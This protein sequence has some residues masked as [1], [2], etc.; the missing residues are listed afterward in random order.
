MATTTDDICDLIRS[1]E[2]KMQYKP[3]RTKDGGSSVKNYV[4]TAGSFNERIDITFNT[5]FV[6]IFAF[7]NRN[8]KYY[9]R[10]SLDVFAEQF[11]AEKI[12][13]LLAAK[14]ATKKKVLC[15]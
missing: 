1:P 11:R 6:E 14:L 2:Y 7:S 9:E 8:S 13:Q 12:K 5:R 3:F 10:L 15:K 4:L